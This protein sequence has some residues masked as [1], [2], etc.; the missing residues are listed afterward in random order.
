MFQKNGELSIE[1]ISC[2]DLKNNKDIFYLID[3]RTD[4]EYVGELGHIQGA[5]LATLGPDL[6]AKLKKL[7]PDKNYVFICRVG[8]RSAQ[9]TSQALALGLTKS[10]N[11]IG[12]MMEWNRL[13]YPTVA[14]N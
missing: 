1:E 13:N 9:A 10:Y 2:E 11:M 14:S 5:E 7:S 4:E 12:G 6:E 8:G 3:V